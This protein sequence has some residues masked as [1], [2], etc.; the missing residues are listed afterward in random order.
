MTGETQ[1]DE[2]SRPLAR[3]FAV[4]EQAMEFRLVNLGLSTSF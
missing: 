2:T 1:D 4:S 3:A